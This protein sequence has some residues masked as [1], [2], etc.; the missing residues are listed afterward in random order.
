MLQHI[1]HHGGISGVCMG[2]ILN[3]GIKSGSITAVRNAKT[4]GSAWMVVRCGGISG[5][6][7]CKKSLPGSAGGPAGKERKVV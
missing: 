3:C 2:S 7:R 6:R 1:V 5:T 4:S